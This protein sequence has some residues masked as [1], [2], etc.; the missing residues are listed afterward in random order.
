MRAVSASNGSASADVAAGDRSVA[1]AFDEAG[2]QL[3]VSGSRPWRDPGLGLVV[4]PVGA[5][6][7]PEDGAVAYRAEA[8]RAGDPDLVREVRGIDDLNALL[9]ALDESL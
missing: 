7:V 9:P 2:E 6:V 5:V 3:G 8:V 1:F 4:A